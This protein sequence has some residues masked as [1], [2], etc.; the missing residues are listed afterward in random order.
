MSKKLAPP[1]SPATAMA[2]VNLGI[3]LDDLSI[4]ARILSMAIAAGG[5]ENI[6]PNSL[7][8]GEAPKLLA[9]AGIG[10]LRR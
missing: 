2:Q 1:P 3:P 9:C 8:T 10:A 7:V 6:A 5:A 4:T